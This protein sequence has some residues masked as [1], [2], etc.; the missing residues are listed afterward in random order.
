MRSK[1]RNAGKDRAAIRNKEARIC[2]RCIKDLILSREISS[3]GS[4]ASCTFCKKQRRT[5]SLADL[6]GRVDPVY[7]SLVK[8][9]EDVRSIDYR[10]K[11]VWS[12][13]GDSP[14]DILQEML[15]CAPEIADALTEVLSERDKWNV[16]DGETDY[17]DST[18]CYELTLPRDGQHVERWQTFCTILRGRRRFFTD[19]LTEILDSIFTPEVIS[20][21]SAAVSVATDGKSLLYRARMVEDFAKVKSI[22]ANPVKELGQPPPELRRAGRMNAAGLPVMYFALDQDTAIAEVRP[23]IGAYIVMAGFIPR[24]DLHLLDLTAIRGEMIGSYFRPDLERVSDQQA[25]L[26]TFSSLIARPVDT[27]QQELAYLPTQFIAEYLQYGVK[28]P[29]DGVIFKSAVH[30]QGKNVVVFGDFLINIDLP[31][32]PVKAE[33]VTF[34]LLDPDGLPSV[35][36]NKRKCKRKRGKSS[37][38]VTS[39]FEIVAN[40][41][42]VHRID[43]IK[44]DT[45]EYDVEIVPSPIH[46]KMF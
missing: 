17:Y 40:S 29:F 23:P 18:S 31:G 21:P 32:F 30:H 19:G 35:S 25:F 12:Q 39:D 2:F 8:P 11:T 5:W 4:K 41:L 33:N 16:H 1:L 42:V 45:S 44:Y 7:K 14:S 9:G 36:I 22:L 13:S 46:N 34:D 38:V 10:D 28:Q 15:S 3:N 26:E 24:K 43:G 37:R 20:L 6:A 27:A